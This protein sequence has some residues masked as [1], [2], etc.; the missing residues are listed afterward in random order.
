VLLIVLRRNAFSRRMRSYLGEMLPLPAH[1]LLAALIF[2]GI[3]AFA[4]HTHH[5]LA[6]LLSRSS[7]VGVTSLF[8]LMLIL[9]LMDELKD[10][11]IDRELFPERPLPSGRVHRADIAWSLVA[12]SLLFLAINVWSGWAFLVAVVVLGY[13]VLMLQRFFAPDRLRRSLPLTLV[14]HNPIVALMVLYSFAVVAAASRLAPAELDWALI[15]PFV[16]MVWFPFLAWELARK[17][18]SPQEETDY[19]TYSRILGR[20]RAVVVVW[21]VQAVSLLIGVYVRAFQQP[22]WG[23]LIPMGAGFLVNVWAGVRFMHDP[24]PRTSRLKPFAT[25]YL[26]CVLASQ[27]V[28]FAAL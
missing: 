3:A 21:I 8:L 20:N 23:Y 16:V 17:I 7:L 13:A 25:S 1:A 15:L 12:A 9:R 18:R 5:L 19:V 27:I 14:T 4:R 26:L 28:G 11:D 24:N 22:H 10:E 2:A 6:S